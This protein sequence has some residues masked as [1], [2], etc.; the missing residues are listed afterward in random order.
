M[1]IRSEETNNFCCFFKHCHCSNALKWA[2]EP[3]ILRYFLLLCFSL[4]CSECFCFNSF[5]F[6]ILPP[7]LLHFFIS[8]EKL[9]HVYSCFLALVSLLLHKKAYI[10]IEY[11]FNCYN[12]HSSLWI[13]AR[14]SCQH[15]SHFALRPACVELC[16]CITFCPYVLHSQ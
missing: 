12:R 9:F 6:V 13:S 8:F 11:Y 5:Y 16:F 14:F 3:F 7:L 1:W 2:N 15:P 10:V 4:L